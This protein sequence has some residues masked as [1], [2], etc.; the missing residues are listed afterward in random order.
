MTTQN[1]NVPAGTTSGIVA[2]TPMT[3]VIFG[4]AVLGGVVTVAFSPSMS[5]PSNQWPTVFT[6]TGGGSYRSLTTGY[7]TITAA[8]QAVNVF[9]A[10]LG[11]GAQGSGN[12]VS[13]NA[14]LA[15]PSSTSEQVLCSWR[16]PPGYLRPGF[17]MSVIG[18]LL[19]TN[20]SDTK[21]MKLY[22]NGTGGTVIFTSP[23]LASSANYTFEGWLAGRL[24]ATIVGGGVLASQTSAQGGYGISTTAQPTITRAF[25]NLE[26][27][28]TLTLTKATTAGNTGQLE[29]LRVGLN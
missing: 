21:T 9:F 17:N 2:I 19:L 20:N 18:G 4:P 12:I 16:T 15:T 25:L 11:P 23:D 14:S 10:D 5:I 8:T 24:G 26:T 29:F 28:F 1:L 7:V 13:I 3:N 27:E 6:G 22:V